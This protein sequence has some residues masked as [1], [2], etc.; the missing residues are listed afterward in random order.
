MCH[1]KLDVVM[2]AHNRWEKMKQFVALF[3]KPYVTLKFDCNDYTRLH[4]YCHTV[5]HNNNNSE[6]H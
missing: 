6:M 2:T 4:T 5:K 3:I 1:C